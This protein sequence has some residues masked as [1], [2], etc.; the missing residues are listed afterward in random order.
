MGRDAETDRLVEALVRP[1]RPSAVLLGPDGIGK[2]SI[3]EG[4]AERVVADEVPAP[5]R[6]A[7]IIEVPISALLA[8]TQYRGQLEERLGQLARE[9]SQPGIVLF[10]EGVDQLPAR[11]GPRAGRG[12]SRSCAAR[13]AGA[14]C[15]S[16][17]PPSPTRSGWPPRR[18]GLDTLLTP[19][20]VPELDREATRPVV[21]ALRDRLASRAASP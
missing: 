1:T 20:S 6:G 18:S 19:I 11:A 14:S 2:A 4:L 10:V 15:G 3:V 12:H 5:L 7:R 21:A 16:S 9:A 8:G 17:A 13:S